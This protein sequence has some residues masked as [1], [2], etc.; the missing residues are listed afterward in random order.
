MWYVIQVAAGE[1]IE[2][3]ERCKKLFSTRL[4]CDV[5]V[6]MYVQQ[7]KYQGVWKEENKVLFPG[8][9]FIET[10]EPDLVEEELTK[11]TCLAKPVYIGGALAVLRD[12]E[13]DILSDMMDAD[14]VIQPSVGYIVDGELKVIKGPLKKY[15]NCVKRID[16]H[17]RIATLSIRFL[18]EE[19]SALVGLE[20]VAKVTKEEF[21]GMQVEII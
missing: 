2:T 8:Y 4:F 14:Y 7:K 17:K 12:E 1:E 21:E 16:R 3:C 9:V 13:Q 19:K 20:V 10:D 18:N 6:P 15:T 11:L 5:F